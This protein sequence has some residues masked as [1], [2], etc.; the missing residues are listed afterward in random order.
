[1]LPM[2]KANGILIAF[3]GL[4]LAALPTFAHHSIAAEFDPTK[5]FTVTGVLTRVEWTNPHIYWYVDVKNES[6]DIET[7]RFQ[8]APPSMLHRAGLLRSDWKIGETVTVS[9][10]PAKDGSKLGFGTNIKYADGHS[11]VLYH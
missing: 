7:W 6:G 9:A 2:N 1:M 10:K 8:G 5:D 11:I 4:F 3:F